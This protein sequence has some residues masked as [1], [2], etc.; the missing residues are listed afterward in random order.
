MGVVGQPRC[1]WRRF[2]LSPNPG[3]P[4]GRS[5]GPAPLR[6]PFFPQGPFVHLSVMIAAYLGRVRTKTLGESEVRGSWRPPLAG[7]G[8]RGLA[9]S[10]GLGSPEQEQA[11]RNAGGSGGGGRGHSL[12]SALQR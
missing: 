8:G 2:P 11:K 3:P 4:R 9:L 1:V 10:L 12:R 5:K 6:G 7:R